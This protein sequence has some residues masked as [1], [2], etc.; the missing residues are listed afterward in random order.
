MTAT[1]VRPAIP[2]G[3][4][5]LFRTGLRIERRFTRPGADPFESFT[6]HTRAARITGPDGSVVFALDDVEVPETWS[7]TAVDIL[8]SKYF[9]RTGVPR[10]D[11]SGAPVLDA[12]GRPQ[13]TGERSAKQVMLRLARA[14]R[15]WGERGGYFATADDAQ[16]F[17]DEMAYMLMAQMVAPNTPQFFNTGL[18]EAYGSHKE[19]EGNYYFDPAA[20]RAVPSAHAYERSAASACYIQGVADEL[21]GEGSIFGLIEREA[22]LF[23]NGSG[24]GA[25]MSRVRARGER[26]SSGG[27]SSGVMSF[28]KVADSAAGAI[29][30]GG[31]TRRA[32][33]MVILDAD[34]PEIE[35]FV[36]CKVAEEDKVAA[37]ARAGY[38]THF[39]GDDSAYA[40]VAYQNANHSVRLP[41]GFMAAVAE[42]AP[43][44]LRARTTGEVVRTVPAR[45]LWERIAEAAWRCADPGVQFDDVIND[46]NT[47]ADTEALR[48]TNPCAE[49]THVDDSACNLAS[50]NV[51]RFFDDAAQ[52]FD[53]DAFAHAVRLTQVM[54]EITVSMCHYPA[55]RIAEVSYR[56]RTTGLGYCNI[57]ALLMRAGLAYDSDPGRAVIAAITALM[58]CG[59]YAASAEL[60]DAVGPC[61]AWDDNRE[62]FARVLRNHRRAAY[63]TLGPARR[64]PEYEGLTVRPRGID[65]LALAHT[66]FADLSPAVLAAADAM[67]A[68]IER[69]GYRNAQVTCIAPTGTIG[70]LMDADTTGIEPDFA[71]VKVKKLAGGGHMRIVNQSVAPALRALGYDDAAITAMMTHLLGTRDLSGP[72]PVNTAALAAAGLRPAE[73]AAATAQLDAVDDLAAAFAPR[74]VGPDTYERLGLDPQRANG[75]DLLARLG[76]DAEAV[77]TSGSVVC[78]HRALEGAPGLAP[79]HLPVFDCA[80]A[81]GTGTRAIHWSGHVRA[82]SA[83]APLISGST[84]KT[85]NLP[86]GATVADVQAAYELA[87]ELGVKCVAVYRDGSKLSQ[88][89]NAVGRDGADAPPTF[90]P[91]TPPDGVSPTAYYAG[92]H[93]PRFRLPSV[94]G[95]LTA[96]IEVGGPD[97]EIY[98]K[99]GEYDD[100]TLGEVFIDW[101][102][103]GSTL[104]GMTS[105]LS[106]AL[107]LALQHGVRLEQLVSAL[108]GH[109]FAPRG[110]V[111]GSDNLKMA[112]S[113]IDAIV[114]LLGYFYLGDERLVQVPHPRPALAPPAPAPAGASAADAA[115]GPGARVVGRT[116]AHCGGTNLRQ[117]GACAVCADCGTSSGCS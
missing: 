117:A 16:A 15:I 112:D 72:Q 17:E 37:L 44:P 89:L 65:H 12:D 53:T 5:P 110:V 85:V 73:I 100:R 79:E 3:P 2:R 68:G 116:C 69:S 35:D 20:G 23:R 106:I 32:A 88:P 58:H 82:L 40:T 86:H 111:T 21:V 48:G 59:A 31:A 28:I 57:G 34:H 108:R 71:L 50:L 80:V 84:S 103:Q 54:L 49:Y 70:L 102:K 52:R 97:G 74:A 29:K 33:K 26:L 105:A 11:A 63:G 66:P 19:P 92:H 113:P 8:A 93:P 56:H 83:V 13:L 4:E 77:A 36:W 78:G 51:V 96:R 101:G 90:L 99:T 114:R 61:A 41:R 81:C 14:W 25:N 115:S 107:S 42:D 45:R 43:W 10:R 24:S 18:F 109:E 91:T 9:R 7:Q 98:V 55:A 47:V 75:A 94:R 30:S 6:F 104:R 27:T 64:V 22:R 76:F 60:A 38:S 95:G 67:I 1:D 46:W 39:E 62:S 87:Y